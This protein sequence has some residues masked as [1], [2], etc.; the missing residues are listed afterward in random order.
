MDEGVISIRVS[1]FVIYKSFVLLWN[2]R[3][4]S[5][6]VAAMCTLNADYGDGQLRQLLERLRLAFADLLLRLARQVGSSKLQAVFLINNYDL[7]LQV[8]Y[9]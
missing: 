7:V 9:T 4:Y 3:R 6:L 2:C 5:E 1:M 8:Q